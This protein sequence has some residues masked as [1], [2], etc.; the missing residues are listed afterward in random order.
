M[1]V[2]GIDP[3]KRSRTA[4]AVDEAGRQ[5]G[6]LTVCSDPQGLLRLWAWA[7]RFGPDRRW[8][9]EDGR[10]IAGRLVRTLIGQG[11]AVV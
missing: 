10:G 4:V 5:L 11:A 6:Q 8:A 2:I 7:S 9:V 1:V 3:R